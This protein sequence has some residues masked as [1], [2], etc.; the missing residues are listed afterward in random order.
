MNVAGK[1]PLV[2]DKKNNGRIMAMKVCPS[3]FHP[4]DE[5][6]VVDEG[7]SGIGY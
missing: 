3:S 1:L 4:S 5:I 6:M 7:V 2:L